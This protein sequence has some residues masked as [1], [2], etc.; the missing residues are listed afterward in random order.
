M[1]DGH[2]YSNNFLRVR[3]TS[4]SLLKK[5]IFD[6]KVDSFAHKEYN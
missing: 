3:V 5:V 1:V 6:I 4:I 2:Y